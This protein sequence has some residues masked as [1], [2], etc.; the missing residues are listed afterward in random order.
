MLLQVQHYKHNRVGGGQLPLF[1]STMT[2]EQLGKLPW[3]F[4]AYISETRK[5]KLNEIKLHTR[6][7]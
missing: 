3:T 1:D 5:I 2:L 6:N 7:M 4:S